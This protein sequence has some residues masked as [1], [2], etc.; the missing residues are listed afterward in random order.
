MSTDTPPEWD[1]PRPAPT[2][3]PIWDNSTGRFTHLA[4]FNTGRITH[5]LR[6]GQWVDVNAP[7]P[8]TM[9]PAPAAPP[10]P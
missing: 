4:D 8:A 5:E 6:D 10:N 1:V 9:A 2:H 3:R 7:Q